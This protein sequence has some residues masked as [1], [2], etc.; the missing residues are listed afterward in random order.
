MKFV[1]TLLIGLVVLSLAVAGNAVA[2]PSQAVKDGIARL[3]AESS[4]ET[5]VSM[6]PATEAAAFVRLQPGS[7][8]TTAAGTATIDVKTRAFLDRFGQAFGLEDQASELILKRQMVAADGRGRTRYRQVYRGIPVFGAELTSHFDRHGQLAAVSASTFEIEGLDITPAWPVEQAVKTA[9]DHVARQG[10]ARARFDGFNVIDAELM[11]FRSGLAKGVAGTN[12]LAYRVE[13]VNGGRSVREFVFVSALTG[14]VLDQ[15]TGIHQALDRKVSE[16]TLDEV[17]WQDSEDDPE[18]IPAGWADGEPDQIIDWQNEIDGARETYNLFASMTATAPGGAWRSYDNADATMLTINNKIGIGCPNATWDGQTANFCPGV[19]SDDTV[20]HEWGHA[21][22][23][24]TANLVYQWQPGALNESYSDVWGEVVDLLNGRGLDSPDALR[25]DGSCSLNDQGLPENDNT[26]R[27]LIGEENTA[28][29]LPVPL[30]DMWRPNCYGDPGRVSDSRYWCSDFDNGGVHT[31]SGIPNHGFALLVDGGTYNGV[32]ITGL[33]LTKATHI[34]WESIQMLVPVSDFPAQADALEASCAILIDSPLPALSTSSTD[35]GPSGEI[36]TADDCAQ[37][38]AVIEAIELR[39][40]PEQC[41]FET[42]LD[43]DPPERCLGRG[44]LQSVSL[45]DW[46]SGLGGWTAGTRDVANPLTFSTPDWAVVGDLPDGRE[47]SAAFVA[48]LAVGNC[49][50]DDESGV[51]TLDSPP[52]TIPAETSVA[53]LS[54]DHW[55]SSERYFDGGN[56]KVS[57]NGGAFELIGSDLIEISPY[58]GSLLESDEENTN[59]LA[60]QPAYSGADGGSLSGSWGQTHVNLGERAGIGDEVRLRFD[61]GLDGCS[62]TVGWYV[63]EV[64]FYSCSDEFSLLCGNGRPDPNEQCDD[65]NGIDGDGCSAVCEVE[66]DWMCSDAVAPVKIPESGFEGGP[67]AQVWNES[68]LVFPTLICSVGTCGDGE[69]SGPAEGTWWAW[70]G[71]LN[72]GETEMA[73]LS[74]TIEIP[75]TAEY[76]RFDLELPVCDS[77]SDYL[78]M[79]IDGNELFHVDGED[80][81]CGQIGYVERLVDVSAYADGGSHTIEFFSEGFAD[82]G[83]LAN[84]RVQTNFFIDNVMIAGKPSVC[85]AAGPI[86]E[87]SPTA[88]SKLDFGNQAL[89]SPGGTQSIAVSNP[90]VEALT[91][92]CA[93]NGGGAVHFNLVSCPSSVPAA[94]SATVEVNCEPDSL[95][96]KSATLDIATNDPAVPLASYP[97]ACVGVKAPRQVITP[98]PSI[99]LVAAAGPVTVEVRYQPS[100][101]D[102]T[103]EGFATRVHWD[104]TKLVFDEFT[105]VWPTDRVSQDTTCQADVSNFDND[106]STD[107]YATITWNSGSGEFPGVGNT[108]T[109]LFAA[110]FTAN[111]A[112]AASTRIRFSAAS[113]APGYVFG[114]NSALVEEETVGPQVLFSDD[115]EHTDTR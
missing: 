93:I 52:V 39:S 16:E 38:T 51:L 101:G 63:D 37:V 49:Q 96:P 54:I 14:K 71:G 83:T 40:K 91:L 15:V 18:T 99:Q 86:F 65:G 66:E 27:W 105:S 26:Y 58:N 31:N 109:L 55:F 19:T 50:D 10:P 41:G 94:G 56:L 72:P 1:H 113:T 53:R 2:D 98:M 29:K 61:F 87:A 64:E 44:D 92:D 89:S 88:G 34:Y 74:Q 84:N 8:D 81:A 82:N 111:F 6:G 112:P 43:V 5:R 48:N 45:T 106:S 73:S 108:P 69:G 102:E 85:I 23:D 3:Q 90:G 32:T 21:Y 103:V 97:L 22:T 33:G 107:C 76:I 68:S 77:A 62:G 7:L 57:V 67:S 36:I 4:A 115:F 17:V 75:L 9:R 60:G 20:A 25:T 42:V 79:R 13:V 70:F 114:S 104:S 95:G 78:L 46:E 11:V 35:A 110:Q 30:R 80:A 100:D 24:Y 12:H 47:G 59:P 28:P